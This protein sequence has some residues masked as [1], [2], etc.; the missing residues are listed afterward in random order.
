MSYLPIVEGNMVATEFFA[1]GGAVQ[2]SAIV[3]NNS[4]KRSTASSS[5]SVDGSGNI[6][7]PQGGS[8][9]LIANVDVTR[10]NVLFAVKFEWFRNGIALTTTEGASLA[11]LTSGLNTSNLLAQVV[12]EAP[13][14]QTIQ[15][16]ETSGNNQTI[17][18][19]MSLLIL[20]V[21]R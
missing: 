17:N 13:T 8:Y 16:R 9:W 10:S 14:E 3:W 12:I 21:S 18:A 7:L 20:E 19:N 4:T 2:N 1:T 15:L 11:V 6:T 5:V